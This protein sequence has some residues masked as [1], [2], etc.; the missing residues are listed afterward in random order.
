[1][2]DEAGLE[3]EV[4]KLNTMPLHLGAFV[5]RNSKRIIINFIHAFDGFYTKYLYY[6]DSDSLYIGKRQ[7]K[8]LDKAGLIGKNLLQSKNDYKDGGIFYGL[9]LA[10]KKKH[11]LTTN[12]Y[13]G[14]DQHKTFE[15]FTNVSDNLN[16]NEYFK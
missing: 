14:F 7:W 9:F 11:C 12:K 3:D 6:K 1:M 2:L 16:G 5:S 4:K 15:G 13:G 8:K 10:P